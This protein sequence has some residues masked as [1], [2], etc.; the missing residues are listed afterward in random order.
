MTIYFFH[1]VSDPSV[2]EKDAQKVTMDHVIHVM[3]LI[4]NDIKGREDFL[5]DST[6]TFQDHEK[7]TPSSEWAMVSKRLKTIR[8]YM[9]R[10]H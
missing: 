10:Q 1:Q 8:V 7:S 6:N 2:V 9:H 3:S 5:K 4:M